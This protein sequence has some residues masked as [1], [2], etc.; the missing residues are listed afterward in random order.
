MKDFLVEMMAYA[1]T[2]GLKNAVCLYAYKGHEEFDLIWR[3]AAALKDLDIF[4]CD[5]YWRWRGKKDPAV[6]V[7]EFSKYTVEHAKLNG[8]ESQIWIQAMRLPSGTEDEIEKAV[9]A[10]VDSGVTHVAA[11][12][13]DGG[14]LLDTVLAENP[15]KV[16]SAVEKSFSKYRNP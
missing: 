15:E 7:G 9:K 12:S 13:Y 2:K 8:K 16:W 10:C 1:K 5:P 3:E 4:G 6:H 11:W 14:E